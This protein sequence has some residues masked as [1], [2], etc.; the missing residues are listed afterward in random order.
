MQR[1]INGAGG[2]HRPHFGR[3]RLNN[4][5]LQGNCSFNISFGLWADF[6]FPPGDKRLF[7]F[8][9]FDAS[10]GAATN[11]NYLRWMEVDPVRLNDDR[12]YFYRQRGRQFYWSFAAAY[13]FISAN[14]RPFIH[15]FV[16]CINNSSIGRPMPIYGMDGEVI[17]DLLN[18][19]LVIELVTSSVHQTLCWNVTL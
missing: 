8:F 1:D 12:H 18:Y 4:D 19:P 2:H 3:L 15:P 16:F 14:H 17:Q 7:A 10:S 11:E 13:N 5:H 6:Y 9:S